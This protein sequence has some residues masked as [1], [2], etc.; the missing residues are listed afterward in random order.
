MRV[1][2]VNIG[3]ELISTI[4]KISEKIVEM[5]DYENVN[6]DVFDPK[7]AEKYGNFPVN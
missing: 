4:R 6:E 2:K 7:E 5:T 3:Q 1:A